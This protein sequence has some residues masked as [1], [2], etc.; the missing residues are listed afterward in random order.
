LPPDQQRAVELK[1]LLDYRAADVA[2]EMGRTEKAVGG[3][4]ARGLEKLRKLLEEKYPP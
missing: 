1:Y 3:L 4:I 2:R